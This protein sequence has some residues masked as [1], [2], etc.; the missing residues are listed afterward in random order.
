MTGTWRSGRCA[1][2]M[3]LAMSL[4]LSTALSGC[5]FET[6]QSLRAQLSETLY[7]REPLYFRDRLGCTAALYS[8]YSRYPKPGVIPVSDLTA[9]LFLMERGRAVAFN[10]GLSPDDISREVIGREQRSGLGIVNAGVSGATGCLE[11]RLEVPLYEAML[12][13]EVVTV[14]DPQ[15]RVLSLIEW[16]QKRVWVLRSYD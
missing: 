6:E 2:A 9:A 4:T 1:R 15:A 14:Y 13:P 3:G 10:V 12:N 16:E 7:L 11:E 5:F 8:L